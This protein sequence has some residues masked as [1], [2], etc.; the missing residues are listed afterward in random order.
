MRTLIMNVNIVNEGEVFPGSL[1]IEDEYIAKIFHEN[2]VEPIT[3]D[4]TID[5]EDK[6]L[7]PGII[8]DQVHFREPGL[9]Y[10]EDIATG[11]A[12]AVA[13]GVT[14]YMDMPNNKPPIISCDSLENK[15][16]IAEEKSLA[17]YSFYFGATNDNIDEILKLEKKDVCGIK[18]FM[19][20][21][22]G[23]ML[24]D[25]SAM[26]IIFKNAALPVAVHSEDEQTIVSQTARYRKIYGENVPFKYH[27]LIRNRD[28]CF[29]ST[30]FAIDLAKKYNTRLHLL[31]LSTLDEMA[32]LENNSP[33]MD[34]QI[35]AEAC[36]H[37]LWFTE[38]DYEEKGGFIKWNPSI[39]S[40]DD[41]EAIWHAL[42]DDRIDLIATDH[43]PH[44]IEEKSQTYFKCPS[45]GPLVQ[46]ALYAMLEFNF[47]Q[48]IS[49]ENI[50]NKMCHSPAVCFG[51]KKRGF[52]REGYFADLVLLDMNKSWTV[53]KKNI[54][55]KCGW[56]VFENQTFHSSV[57]TTFVNG[58]K[59]YDNGRVTYKSKGKRLLFDR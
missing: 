50:A 10:K 47:M 18:V 46:H 31:H 1:L 3:V 6:Y 55:Y 14:S 41:R 23:G 44:T 12:A 11:S 58:V 53:N 24:V 27:S 19:G 39:K 5:A 54:L 34:K 29:K 59:A 22:T 2:P 28:A 30:V 48:K 13:G 40:A 36:I 51:I 42:L 8:D 25:K 33:L 9:E 32:L 4:E 26:E 35:T 52:I 37:H 21:S 56:S 45:G 7:L 43:A 17:N 15:Y 57:C 20:S 16:K 38:S 49:L